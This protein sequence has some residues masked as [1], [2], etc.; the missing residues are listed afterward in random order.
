M[1]T[2]K[3]KRKI[4]LL[5]CSQIA[6]FIL[7]FFSNSFSLLNYINKSFYLSSLLLLLSLAIYT[8]NTGF[9]DSVTK[10]FRLIFGGKDIT[11]ESVEEMRPLSKIITFNYSSLMVIGFF[12]L[13]LC[14]LALFFYYI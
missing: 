11:R 8:V 7:M 2:L 12:N 14:L 10:S 5:L 9:F 3:T 4:A 13:I 1:K 6:I